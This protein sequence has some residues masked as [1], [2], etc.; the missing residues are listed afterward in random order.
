ML[1]LFIG[2]IATSV[3]QDV[4]EIVYLKNGSVV[5]GIVIEQVPGVSL[6]IQTSDGSIFAYPMSDVEKI[7]KE[8]I[9]S[10]SSGNKA[11]YKG[12]LDL[13]YTF[14]IGDWGEDR[15]SFSTSHGYQINP[16][17]FTGIGVGVNYYFD[18]EL[19][20]IP[21]F[22]HIRANFLDREISPY[23]D[24]KIGYSPNLDFEGLYMSPSIG[25][26]IG[27]FNLGVG[28]VMQK[29]KI[30][31]DYYEISETINCGGISVKLGFEF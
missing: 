24:F 5:R 6:K 15:L 27:S 26:K 10:K 17:I 11:G 21:I 12:F 30:E 1:L 25:C 23:I 14:G 4:Q 3:A 18:S 9:K 28:Y 16:Y 19:F 13:G 20:A 8:S 31:D 2:S 22:A 7:T 29:V